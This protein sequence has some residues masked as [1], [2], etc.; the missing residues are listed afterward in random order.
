MYVS[1]EL[2][3]DGEKEGFCVKITTP[4]DICLFPKCPDTYQDEDVLACIALENDINSLEF[5]RPEEQKAKEL[6]VAVV[7]RIREV[8]YFKKETW[9]V[10]IS[11][12]GID[13]Y[14]RIY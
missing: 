4:D 1:V 10:F 13:Y 6:A 7:E 3:L 11:E 9:R 8:Y 2:E 14:G 5:W 12:N